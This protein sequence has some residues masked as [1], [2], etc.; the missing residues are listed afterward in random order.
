MTEFDKSENIERYVKGRLEGAELEA[1]EA[2]MK[3]DPALVREVELERDIAEAL[4]ESDVAAFRKTLRQVQRELHAKK[5]EPHK[6]ALM[7]RVLAIAASIILLVAAGQWLL[8]KNTAPPASAGELFASY[9]HLPVVLSAGGKPSRDG[10]NTDGTVSP[11]MQAWGTV[12]ELFETGD[13]EG[14]LN[15]LKAFPAPMIENSPSKYHYESGL[16][17]L[18]LGHPAE[19]LSHFGKITTGYSDEKNWYAALALLKLEG[20][21]ARVKVAF[22]GVAFKQNPYQSISLKLLEEWE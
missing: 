15:H 9:F 21:T 18:A 6:V 11:E 10:K 17:E 3:S 5:N 20:K 7:W 13:F 16:L 22:Q 8:R 12:E 1:F 14:A 4:S 2:L 19:A